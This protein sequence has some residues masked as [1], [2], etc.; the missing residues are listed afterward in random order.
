LR[1]RL[2]SRSRIAMSRLFKGH[3]CSEW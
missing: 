2:R 3:A 1:L